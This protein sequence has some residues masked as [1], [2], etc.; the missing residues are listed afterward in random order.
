M[1]ARYTRKQRPQRCC[2][3]KKTRSKENRLVLEMKKKRGAEPRR[4][5]S[6]MLASGRYSFRWERWDQRIMIWNERRASLG[7]TA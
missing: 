2:K 6:G 1:N 3:K 7:R 4:K 5:V